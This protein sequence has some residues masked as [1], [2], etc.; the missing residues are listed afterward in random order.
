MI[1]CNT[2]SKY[3]HQSDR[4]AGAG[5]YDSDALPQVI[6]AKGGNHSVRLARSFSR[7]SKVILLRNI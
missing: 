1:P 2:L 7:D 3:R 5:P 6:A 4:D